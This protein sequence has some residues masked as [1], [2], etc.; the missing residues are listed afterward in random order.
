MD[1]NGIVKGARE[2]LREFCLRVASRYLRD[3]VLTLH[4][5]TSINVEMRTLGE[6][7]SNCDLTFD[8]RELIDPDKRLLT[9][10]GPQQ[11][12]EVLRVAREALQ[13][14]STSP[15][16]ILDQDLPLPLAFLV[17][18]EWRITSRLRLTIRQRTGATFNDID[19]DGRVV[20]APDPASNP[21]QGNGPVV[22]AVSCRSG[23]GV[24]AEKYAD[25]AG[26]RELVSLHA[27]GI[28]SPPEI[29]GL[30]RACANELRSLNNRGVEKHLLMLG[31]STLAILAGVASNACGPVAIPFWDSNKYVNPLTVYCI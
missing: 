14:I 6:P 2:T 8:W 24:M 11:L 21:L 12:V 22:L 4:G 13:A 16:I 7:S 9:N 25:E 15:H 17:G 26:A 5:N 27:D 1:C 10:D 29:R 28:L 3:A 18:H 20:S 30:A 31:P 19:G 23:L